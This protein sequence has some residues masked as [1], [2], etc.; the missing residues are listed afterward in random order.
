MLVSWADYL[1]DT[2]PF[3]ESQLCTDDFTGKLANNTNLAAKGIVALEAFA[4]LCDY[5]NDANDAA[6]NCSKY[7]DAARGFAITWKHYAWEDDHFDWDSIVPTEIA[8][9]V[10]KRNKYGPPM[11]SRHT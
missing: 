8:Y 4:G 2:L 6:D 10:S 7:R 11:D 9:Y 3:P 1:M 5:V